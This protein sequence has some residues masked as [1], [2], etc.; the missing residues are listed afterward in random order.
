MNSIVVITICIFALFLVV[1]A[2]QNIQDRRLLKTVTKPHRGTRSERLMVLSLLKSGI[3][4][5]AMF[6]DLYL[7]KKNGGYCQID[8]VVATKV[9]ILVLEIKEYNGWI[10]GKEN[11]TYW[12]QL[13]AFGK[14]K[15]RF[16]NPILQNDKH[17]QELRN[18]LPQFKNVPFYSVIVFFGNCSFKNQ[19]NLPG[20][21]FLTKDSSAIEIVNMI[22]NENQPAQYV[23]KQE[24]VNLWDLSVLNG[25]NDAI[26]TEHVRN[27]RQSIR[28]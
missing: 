10:F 23:N 8:L 12:T 2:Y 24:I 28:Y 18:Q 15:Y 21:T 4:P 14:R 13:L 19:V 7:K 25:E 26:K 5:R 22:M 20:H 17:I 9:G 11:Q 27:I 6:H 16:Y 3:A 1:F